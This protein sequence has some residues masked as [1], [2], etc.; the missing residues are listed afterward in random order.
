[1]A[2]ALCSSVQAKTTVVVTGVG[3]NL[4]SNVELI[5]GAAPDAADARKYRRYVDSLPE[6]AL[7]AL[8]ALGYYSA[9]VSISESSVGEDTK[10]TVA[11]TP[12]DP[13]LV[14][15]L[16]VLV[17][18]DGF[19]DPAYRSVLSELPII[20]GAIF[21]S[22]N[23]EAVKTV[24]QDRAQD[25]GYFDF[26]FTQSEV[27]VSRK[28]LSAN[29]KLTADTGVRYTYG[30]ILFEQSL[31][32]KSFLDRWLPFNEGDP[33]ES[34]LIGEL[35]Q[36]LQN[37]GYFKSVR[38]Q[39]QQDRRYGKTIPVKVDLTP[40]DNN[41]VAV[42]LGFQTDTGVRTKL[43]WGKPLINRLGH[44][45][46]AALSL[47]E[48]EQNASFSYRVPRRKEPLYNYWGVEF[49]VKN[50]DVDDTE[51]FL[52]TLNFQRVSRTPSLWTEFLFIRWERERFTAGSAEETTDLVLP[53]F[54]YSKTQS[55]GSPFPVWG[56][57]TSIQ[58]LG[59]STRALSSIE[60]FKIIGTFRYLRALSDRN[61]IISAVQYG[62]IQSNDYDRVPISQRFFAGGDRSV[63]GFKYR[64]LSPRNTDNEA[65]G[66]RYLEI[67]SL[68]YN[69]R[70]LDRWS[71]ALFTDAGR[72]FNSFREPY[73][74][75][76]GFG[77][78]W[79]SP[80]GPFRVDIATPISDNDGGD[81]RVHLSLGPDL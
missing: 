61:T 67:L 50:V 35:T 25:L 59:G 44:S 14:N 41:Q 69:Y 32:K 70:F 60:F 55:K 23:Y 15:T 52:S 3:G 18:G 51:S 77:I 34:G 30:P 5:A 45:A 29:I 79:Q 22:A 37:S 62:A 11:V 9:T 42:G 68:E 12:N 74:V 40:K 7:D 46:D 33:Y 49:G 38:V 20:K 80:V 65:V 47:S 1:M 72:A 13:V 2:V 81:V 19:D 6:L 64:D 75:G 63:R 43:T 53:G 21:V 8:S 24:L 54:S 56:Q 10:I 57:S 28:Q 71:G 36:N 76:A 66:G 78:R 17:T 27:R 58:V 26:V 39:P 73:S 31:F 48:I 16:E 4:K